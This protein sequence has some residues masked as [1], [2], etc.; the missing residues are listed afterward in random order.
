MLDAFTCSSKHS[1]VIIRVTSWLSLQ[2]ST[3]ILHDQCVFYTFQIRGLKKDVVET[4]TTASFNSL[5][6]ALI[7]AILPGMWYFSWSNIFPDKGNSHDFHFACPII[8][9]FTAQVRESSW[10]FGQPL[11]ILIPIIH[12]EIWR[13]TVGWVWTIQSGFILLYE[14]NMIFEEQDYRFKDFFSWPIKVIYL[15]L[16]ICKCVCLHKFLKWYICLSS[17]QGVITFA[18]FNFILAQIGINLREIFC[19]YDLIA[20]VNR[21][22]QPS[23]WAALCSSVSGEGGWQCGKITHLLLYWSSVLMTSQFILLLLLLILFLI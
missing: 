12:P 3:V 6:V 17:W 18:G 14:I 10:R 9:A 21:G 23:L 20:Q 22:F 8:I 4:T 13:I 15:L 2:Y 1:T 11:R 5:M 19:T 16:M 7:S